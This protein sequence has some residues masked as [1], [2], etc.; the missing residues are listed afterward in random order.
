[1]SQTPRDAAR[2]A[3][4]AALP[5]GDGERFAG[6]GIMGLPFASGHV[7]ALR[8]FATSIGPSYSSVG[9]RSPDGK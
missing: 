2:R 3:D 5:P 6:F 7:L 1:M 9:H 4:H 8:R